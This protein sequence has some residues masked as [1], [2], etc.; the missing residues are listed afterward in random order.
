MSASYK[1]DGGPQDHPIN[2]LDITLPL[3]ISVLISGHRPYIGIQFLPH[4]QRIP[5]PIKRPVN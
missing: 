4:I 1:T 3:E 2:S 5:F